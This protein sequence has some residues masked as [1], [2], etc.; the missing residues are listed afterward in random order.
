V[1]DLKKIK[2][3]QVNFSNVLMG[4]AQSKEEVKKAG[5]TSHGLVGNDKDGKLVQAIEGHSYGKEK[6]EEVLKELL[7]GK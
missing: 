6:V 7:Q 1:N 3:D 2:G 4:S 5:L